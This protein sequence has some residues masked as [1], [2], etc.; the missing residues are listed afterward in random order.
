MH[1]P[2]CNHNDM[3]ILKTLTCGNWDGSSLYDPNNIGCC[4]N[5]GHVFNVLSEDDYKGLMK[6]YGNEYTP[7]NLRSMDKVS[8]KPGSENVLTLSRFEELYDFIKKSI[9]KKNSNILDVGCA[10]GGFLSYLDKMKFKNICG[11]DN[12]TEYVEMAKKRGL[13]V[14]EGSAE[15][16]RFEDK[17]FDF[18]V[19]DQV[20]EHIKDPIQVFSELKRV[21]KGDGKICIGV[22]DASE[23]INHYYFDF[24]YFLMR[25]HIQHF[26]LAHLAM[27]AKESGLKTSSSTKTVFSMV[28]GDMPL[29]NIYVLFSSYKKGEAS[30]WYDLSD[31]K[32]KIKKYAEYNEKKSKEKI[33]IFKDLAKKKTPLYVWGLG[34]EFLYMYES[35]G[36]KNCNI[37]GLIDLNKEKQ[38]KYSIDGM[39]VTDE[40]ILADAEKDAIALISAPAHEKSISDSIKKT[41]F[42]GEIGGFEINGKN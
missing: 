12:S 4:K 28:G 32:G 2:S 22:P 42:K 9:S 26:D 33:I 21:M 40:S 35:L 41:G 18:I 13:S 7:V 37:V 14:E 25:E 11:I 23:Y 29:P 31:V 3:E 8:D 6:Y 19:M 38:E 5:C 36:L 24:Y 17:S 30:A 27:M 39:T 20:M 10:T 1:W 16:L 15:C 34:R